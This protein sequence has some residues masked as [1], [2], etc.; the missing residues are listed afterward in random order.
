MAIEIAGNEV[1]TNGTTP[2]EVIPAPAAST[3]HAA[4]A[5]SVG[6]HNADD[7]VHTVVWRKLKGATAT[8]IQSDAAVA[9]GGRS[10][11]TKKVALDATDESLQVVLGEA[12][13]A[14]ASRA[15]AL[16]L[17]VTP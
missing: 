17:V 15:D 10:V 4:P 8:I 14:V 16:Y 12:H 6:L 5:S 9:V 13:N 3:V 1:A 11:L 2:V 7:V